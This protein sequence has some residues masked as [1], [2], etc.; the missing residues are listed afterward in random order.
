MAKLLIVKTGST[1]PNLRER[2]G[3]FEDWILEAMGL[4][5]EQV[6]VVSVHEDEALPSPGGPRGVVVTGSSAM[7]SEREVWS[8][9]TAEWLADAVA[10][11]TPVLGICYGH[12][13]LAHGLGGRVGPN[14][15]GRQI[16]TLDLD[17]HGAW[18][19]DPLLGGL[20]AR[21]RV[22]VS[23]VESVL[24]LPPGARL[25]GTTAGDPHHAFA[26]GSSVWGVQF[27]PEFDADV[28]RTYLTERRELVAVEG[29]DPDRLMREVS[30]SDVG[31]RLLRRFADLVRE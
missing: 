16:G 13:L 19:D 6:D 27:H 18:R 29:L 3:D 17:L 8:E 20:E 22:Q 10:A 15:N 11:G 31:S 12:Q 5:R 30:E 21:L 14:P 1:F 28:T 23:H 24:V 2:R 7:V 4:P 25:L 26:I 9:R